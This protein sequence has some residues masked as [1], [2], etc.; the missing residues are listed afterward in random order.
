MKAIE[1]INEE[2]NL[3]YDFDTIKN[4]TKLSKST[5]YRI[6]N[7]YGIKKEIKYKNQFLYGQNSLFLIME[8]ALIRKTNNLL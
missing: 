2:D 8:I 1:Y 5:L 6:I 7:N 4:I 3:Y